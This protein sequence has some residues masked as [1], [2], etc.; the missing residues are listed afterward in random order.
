MLALMDVDTIVHTEIA[1][2]GTADYFGDEGINVDS[3][4]DKACEAIESWQAGAQADHCL[5]AFSPQD[6]GNF[7]H[8][9]GIGYKASRKGDKVEEYWMLEERLK[10]AFPW[11]EI[12]Y[13]E[14]DDAL[15]IMHTS[16]KAGEET[17]IVSI[18]KDMKT[19]P[20]LLFN[21]NKQ[22]RPIYIDENT[23]TWHWLYQTLM[24]DPVDEYKGC[25]RIGQV[26]AARILPTP[27]LEDSPESYLSAAWASVYRTYLTAYGAPD[28]AQ[29]AA[30]AQAR[31]ARILHA[32][33]YRNGQ[34]RLWHPDSPEWVDAQEFACSR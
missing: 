28:K 2:A 31:A 4:F 11:Y 10:S 22:D 16:D 33:D 6:R 19:I 12:P 8:G 24:G 20:G 29:D 18:D 17:V 15:G 26:K 1:A 25:P 3:A 32:D 9:L 5:L 13:L 27:T 23:A 7:R 30:V 21:P 14:G 34:V